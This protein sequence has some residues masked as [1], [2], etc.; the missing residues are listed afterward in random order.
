MSKKMYNS[1]VEMVRDIA[2]DPKTATRLEERIRRTKVVTKLMAIRASKGLT[3]ADIAHG[4]KCSQGRVSKFEASDD[5][6]LRLGDLRSYLNSLNLELGLL[7]APEQWTATDQIKFHAYQIRDCLGRLV[8][9][10]KHDKH[11]RKTVQQFHVETLYDLVKLIAES[12]QNLPK[13]SV[14]SP[15]FLDADAESESDGET[16]E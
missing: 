12:A 15:G 2:E 11:I 7:I 9:L 8:E 13:F 14:G 1:V 5:D 6:D 3:Q 4:M 16:N 10:A